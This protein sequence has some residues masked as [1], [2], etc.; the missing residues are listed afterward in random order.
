MLLKVVLVLLVVQAREKI[1]QVHVGLTRR[2]EDK[3]CGINWV[4]DP[5]IRK[6]EKK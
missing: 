1:I 4:V 2:E 6:G 3:S 5:N